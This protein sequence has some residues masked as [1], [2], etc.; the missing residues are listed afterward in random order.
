MLFSSSL[1]KHN[2]AYLKGVSMQDL[3]NQYQKG[4]HDVIRS[5]EINNLSKAETKNL[6]EDYQAQLRKQIAVIQLDKAKTDAIE[7]KM[8]AKTGFVPKEM[9]A[10][11]YEELLK[12]DKTGVLIPGFPEV[13]EKKQALA[14]AEDLLQKSYAKEITPGLIKDILN[15]YSDEPK[16]QAKALVDEV[17]SIALNKSKAA[18]LNR[19]EVNKA[20]QKNLNIVVNNPAISDEIVNEIILMANKPKSV[21]KTKT[22]DEYPIDVKLAKRE[23]KHQFIKNLDYI[24]TN[25]AMTMPYPPKTNAGDSIEKELD[26]LEKTYAPPRNKK[27]QFTKKKK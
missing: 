17:I 12:K 3:N 18:T 11:E 27:G 24:R 5:A 22:K 1:E 16:K 8:K 23:K 21:K 7:Q 25:K 26:I 9:T 19:D 2:K 20:I 13:A 10:A 4:Q 14:P 15:L 6:M